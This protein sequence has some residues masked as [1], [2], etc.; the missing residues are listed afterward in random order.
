MDLT[1]NLPG[2][3][4]TLMLADL[5]ARVVKVEPPDGDP[6]RHLHPEVDG[7]SPLFHA[8][9]RGKL[10]VCLDL[11]TREGRDKLLHL[12]GASSI[13]VEGF[14][15]G[16]LE[17]LELDPRVLVRRFSQL[18]VVRLSGFGQRGAFAERPG[19]DLNFLAASGALYGTS[20]PNPPTFQAADVA[21]ALL[22]V[23]R[24]L[25]HLLQAATGELGTEDKVVDVAI[26]DAA[27]LLAFPRAAREQSGEDTSPGKGILEGGVPTYRLFE[28][29]D[30]RTVAV[31]ALEP[32][33]AHEVMSG[34]GAAT[35]KD[36]AACIESLAADEI[37]VLSLPCVSPVEHPVEALGREPL[38][39]RGLSREMKSSRG[40]ILLPVTPFTREV[41]AGPW[42]PTLGQHDHVLF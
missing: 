28:T 24:V 33:Y 29:R 26:L 38:S 27:A 21:A 5:G 7:A 19:H 6:V 31:G 23:G 15:P 20:P 1:Q 13:V 16:V 22:C 17:R 4:A 40:P 42:A 9:N 32:K 12:L 39:S 36:L 34:L 25:A 8:L 2:P 37:A 41:P 10:S 35:P 18:T 11:K 14:R 30:G 3:L